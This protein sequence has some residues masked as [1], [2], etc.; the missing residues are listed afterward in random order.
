MRKSKSGR[1]KGRIGRE[2]EHGKQD[3]GGQ[4]CVEVETE[5]QTP[6]EDV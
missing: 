2:S 4:L 3:F 6:K 5:G 1:G